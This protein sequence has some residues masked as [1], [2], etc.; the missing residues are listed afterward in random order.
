MIRRSKEEMVDYAG[1]LIYPMR[2][3][4]TLSYELSQGEVGE[5]T[6]YDET[7]DYIENICNRASVLNRSAARLAM[8]IFQRRLA[9]S[10]YA[11]M[12]S[13]ERRRQ[14]IG[15]L[16]DAIRSGQITS[17]QLLAQQRG[18]DRL[19]DPLESMTA[20]E[21]SAEDS[22]EENEAKEAQL[23]AGVVATNLKDLGAE[24]ERVDTLYRLA[25]Q[26][27]DLGEDSKFA[28]LREVI[29][30]ERFAGE[31]L[32]IFTE[33]RDTLD[34]LVR[35]FEQLGY[36]GQIAQIHGGMSTQVDPQTGL[37]ER[38]E[39]VELFRKP[40]A[41]GGARILV[42]TDAAGD[43]RKELP[44]LQAKGSMIIGEQQILLAAAC[45]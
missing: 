42:A 30:D 39:Q 28:R 5:Q 14:R 41:E 19:A 31:K 3:S 21:E 4:D 2:V 11:L 44:R 27:Y 37:S 40:A 38:D 35:S 29:G 32:I 6:L 17:E 25:Q 12:R 16:I 33:H 10:T 13:L 23:L 15:A 26:V 22:Q 9:S 1:K 7:T 24:R 45:E 43:V 36:T 20:N 34:F 8:S 18:L